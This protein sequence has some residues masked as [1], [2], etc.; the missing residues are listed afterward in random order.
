MATGAYP[1]GASGEPNEGVTTEM[2]SLG[3]TPTPGESPASAH[4]ASEGDTFAERPEIFVGGAFVGGL[5][6]AKLLGRLRR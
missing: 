3:A 1:A 4:A 6:L 5:V 2:P